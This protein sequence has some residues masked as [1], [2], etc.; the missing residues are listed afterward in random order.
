MIIKTTYG[1]KN[2]CTSFFIIYGLTNIPY[3]GILLNKQIPIRGIAKR[4]LLWLNVQTLIVNV[5]IAPAVKIAP[6]PRINAIVLR[7]AIFRPKKNSALKDAGDKVTR[8]FYALLF[9]TQNFMYNDCMNKEPKNPNHRQ[10]IPRLNR[11]IGQLEGIKKM[12]EEQRYCPDIIIQL[13]AVRSA[14]KRV[15]SNILK[16]HLENCVVDS[17]QDKDE[18]KHKIMEI[19]NLLDK[20]QN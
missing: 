2:G 7:N 17:F 6:V 16:S 14:I 19:K 11:A 20:L 5:L 18:A 10:E 4:R 9:I 3:G 13:K 8:I 15:E 12:I 1:L